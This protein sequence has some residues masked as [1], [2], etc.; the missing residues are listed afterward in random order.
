MQKNAVKFRLLTSAN[1]VARGK[2]GQLPDGAG[3]TGALIA[4]CMP[5]RVTACSP[6]TGGILCCSGDWPAL[7]VPKLW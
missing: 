4:L 3:L 5:S 6:A 7:A 2:R 1:C